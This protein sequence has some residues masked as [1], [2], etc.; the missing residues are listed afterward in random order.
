MCCVRLDAQA[1]KKKD[2]LSILCLL[3]K[4]IRRLMMFY[5]AWLHSGWNGGLHP[6]YGCDNL[7]GPPK[8]KGRFYKLVVTPTILY[9]GE[10]WLIKCHDRWIPHPSRD[11]RHR[12][13]RGLGQG[14]GIRHN[15]SSPKNAEKFKTFI[16]MCILWYN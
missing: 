8:I 9:K 5:S 16:L 7:K 13:L 15:M 3:L 2:N 14:L 4:K 12:A 11:R 1:I 6:E 10:F